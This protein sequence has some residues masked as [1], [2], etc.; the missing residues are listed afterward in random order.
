MEHIEIDSGREDASVDFKDMILFS[1][2]LR[3]LGLRA[4]AR[5]VIGHYTI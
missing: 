2:Q 5:A 3:L 1:D 4:H